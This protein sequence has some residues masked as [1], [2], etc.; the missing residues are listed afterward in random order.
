MCSITCMLVVDIE[1]VVKKALEELKN[2]QLI[3]DY[4]KHEQ[5]ITE[6]LKKAAEKE[7]TLTTKIVH[8]IENKT[9]REVEK[10]MTAIIGPKRVALIKKSFAIETY[11]MKVV[12]TPD[13]QT[14]VHVHRRGIEFQPKRWL[15]TIH[16]IVKSEKL[17]WASL[18]IELYLFVCSCA[19]IKV[20]ISEVAM[21]NIVREVEAHVLVPAFNRE[22]NK[23]VKAWNE[24]GVSPWGKAEAIFN[25]LKETYLLQISWKFIKVIL[26]NMSTP[27]TITEIGEIVLMIV[28]SV[29]TNGIALIARI[30]LAVDSSVYL[31]QKIANLGGFSHLKKTIH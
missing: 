11:R 20:D 28:A 3:S 29:A 31:G 14:V 21:M 9:V 10:E 16:D 27:Q 23:F 19:N 13:G 18:V 1:G 6:V 24:A 12:K 4:E 22:L 7:A 30:A 25:I 8:M 5:N 17:Q 26:Q 2:N 15:M